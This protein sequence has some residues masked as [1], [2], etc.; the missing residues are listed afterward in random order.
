MAGVEPATHRPPD[1]RHGHAGHGLPGHGGDP[2]RRARDARRGRLRPLGRLHRLHVRDRAGLRRC[3]PRASSQRALV[4]GGDIL[5][6]VARLDR[7]LDARPLRRRRR[8]G[9]ARARSSGAASSASSSAP[10]APAAAKLLLPASGSRLFERRRTRYLRM[11]GARGV[12]VRDPGDGDARRRRSSTTCGKTVDDVDVY[13]PHQANVR[14]IDH[15]AQEARLPEEKVVVN[16]DRYGNTSS[17][18]IPLALADAADD[19][20]LEP[21]NW[22]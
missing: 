7:P 12:Q 8:R 22:C 19:G 2:R 17:G 13:V 21:G 9:R 18:S 4:V 1:R 11:N 5:S 15:A 10:T 16:V 20:R 14:I 3:S 6:R